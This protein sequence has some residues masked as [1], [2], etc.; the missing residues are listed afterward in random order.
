TGMD[1]IAPGE[2]GESERAKRMALLQIAR[3]SGMREMGLQWARGMVHPDRLD[4]P[5]FSEVLDMVA[6]FTPEVF[7]A[8]INALLN[9]PDAGDVLRQ[10]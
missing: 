8:Q 4:T 1:P 7:A 5:L 9:R 10:L 2:A 6:R 3:H